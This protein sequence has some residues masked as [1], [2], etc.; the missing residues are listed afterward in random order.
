[1]TSEVE[2]GRPSWGRTLVKWIAVTAAFVALVAFSVVLAKLTL[3]PSEASA[4]IAHSN[5][6]PGRSLRQYAEDYTFLGACKQVGGNLLIGVPFGV[7]MPVLVPRRMRML[8]VLAIATFVMVVIELAQGAVIEGRAFDID[9]VIMNVAGAFIG[10]VLLGRKFA[11]VRHEPR[12]RRAARTAPPA[13]AD[14]ATDADGRDVEGTDGGRRLPGALR[15]G[16]R[17]GAADTATTTTTTTSTRKAAADTPAD[18]AT[19]APLWRR[20]TGGGSAA[21]TGTTATETR[22]KETRAT[23]GATADTEPTARRGP[24]AWLAARRSGD[25][26]A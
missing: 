8:R 14:D 5:M 6:H 22:T 19:R 16:S 20:A 10:Y 18:T 2:A 4:G 9:D 23:T 3:T 15:R 11:H 25:T 21:G 1:M 13:V 24:G 17:T 12:A 7:L 26:R